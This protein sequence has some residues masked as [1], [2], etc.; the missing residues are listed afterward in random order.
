[1]GLK[2]SSQA[3]MRTDDESVPKAPSPGPGTQQLSG[4][5]GTYCALGGRGREPDSL[6]PP[7]GHELEQPFSIS[8]EEDLYFFTSQLSPFLSA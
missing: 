3:V 8:E 4:P 5:P 2:T 6:L 7:R 1:M